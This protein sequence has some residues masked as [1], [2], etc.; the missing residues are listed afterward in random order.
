ML[1]VDEH[2]GQHPDVLRRHH[3][4]ECLLLLLIMLQ[5]E[6]QNGPLI[7]RTVADGEQK[8]GIERSRQ[9][10]DDRIGGRTHRV[11]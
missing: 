5:A 9:G 11:S 7:L 4:G 1:V 10:S 8:R 2:N 6:V 3:N